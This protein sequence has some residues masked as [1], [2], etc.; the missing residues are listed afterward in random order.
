MPY[1]PL[2]LVT[3]LVAGD[4]LLWNWSQAGSHD[5]TALL[6]GLT[7][8]LLVIVFVRLLLWSLAHLI[9]SSARQSRMRMRMLNRRR[10]RRSANP[11]EPNAVSTASIDAP[12]QS[13][14]LAA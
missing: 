6:S 4:Y 5:T 7:L 1:R 14:K 2:A 3:V 11:S 12:P 9:A 13:H 8:P 10:S